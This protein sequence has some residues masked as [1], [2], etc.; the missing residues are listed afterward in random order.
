MRFAFCE[1]IHA[2]SESPWHIRELSKHGKKLG[3]GVDTPSLCGLIQKGKGWDLE[4]DIN[5]FHLT[6]GCCPKCF[7]LFLERR[8][9]HAGYRE[10]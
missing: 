5:E 1:S 3:G 9:M 2:S 10:T 7:E 4:T 8:S 6:N